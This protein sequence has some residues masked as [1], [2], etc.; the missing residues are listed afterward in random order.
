VVGAIAAVA[1]VFGVSVLAAEL[2]GSDE[3]SGRDAGGPHAS[4]ILKVAG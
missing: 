3:E 1:F 4:L 2:L